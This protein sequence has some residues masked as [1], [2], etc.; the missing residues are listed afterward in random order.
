MKV[1]TYSQEFALQRG[2]RPTVRPIVLEE[3][4]V[5]ESKRTY[6]GLAQADGSPSWQEDEGKAKDGRGLGQSQR[7]L[8]MRRQRKGVEAGVEV[9]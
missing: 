4:Y 2:H 7:H 6:L 3:L 5:G 1:E 8:W 9:F